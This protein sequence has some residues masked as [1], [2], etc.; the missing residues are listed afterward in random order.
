MKEPEEITSQK[1][2]KAPK[3]VIG[4]SVSLYACGNRN[5]AP[6]TNLGFICYDEFVRSDAKYLGGVNNATY[7]YEQLMVL[8]NT[9]DRGPHQPKKNTSFI[10]GMGN[11]F[12]YNNPLFNAKEVV[13]YLRP[14]THFCSPKAEGWMVWQM[15]QSDNKNAKSFDSSW[16]YWLCTDKMRG[17]IFENITAENLNKSDFVKQIKNPGSY[18]CTIAYD[19]HFYGVYSNP[20]E[21]YLYISKKYKKDTDIYSLTFSDHRPNRLLALSYASI[22][23]IMN[24]KRF[25]ESGCVFF[26][27]STIKYHIDTYF[28]YLL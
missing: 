7:E 27:T 12:S 24:I 2:Y 3:W 8:Y 21:G 4:R 15:R 23:P 25:Y 10:I 17:I 11:S 16:S 22:E 20:N 28:N 5:G 6:L 26:E 14:E 19:G 1:G 9:L 18:Y 13:K